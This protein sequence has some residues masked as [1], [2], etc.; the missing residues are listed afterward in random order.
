M[1]AR[2]DLQAGQCSSIWYPGT[3]QEISG[4]GYYGFILDENGQTRYFN[5]GYTQF[6]PN[7]QGLWVGE[8][9]LFAPIT[10][11]GDRYGKVGC[12]QPLYCTQ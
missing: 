1:K 12:V 6:C 10:E 8:R 2:T 5:N 7:S 3:V 4:G 11:P 9:V